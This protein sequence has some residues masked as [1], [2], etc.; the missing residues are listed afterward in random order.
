MDSMES[1]ERRYFRSA[2][3]LASVYIVAQ[4]KVI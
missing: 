2:Y 4:E 3:L 1:R